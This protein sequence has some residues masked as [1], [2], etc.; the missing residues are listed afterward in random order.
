VVLTA[1]ICV[2]EFLGSGLERANTNEDWKDSKKKKEPPCILGVRMGLPSNY[3]GQ[4]GPRVACGF[5]FFSFF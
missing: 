1:Q 4:E 3:T 2:V 5:F